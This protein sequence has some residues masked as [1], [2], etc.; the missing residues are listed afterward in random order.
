MDSKGH[1]LLTRPTGHLP[2]AKKCHRDSHSSEWP[3]AQADTSTQLPGE[4]VLQT[5]GM[6]GQPSPTACLLSAF[7]LPLHSPPRDC[8]AEAKGRRK[9]KR[10]RSGSSHGAFRTWV[11]ACV[12]THSR[13]ISWCVYTCGCTHISQ[14]GR[15]MA[16]CDCPAFL[17]PGAKRMHERP[18]ESWSGDI[19]AEKVTNTTGRYS[20][21]PPG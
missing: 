20:P 14:P 7:P 19:S 8:W 2:P 16:L 10:N 1:S 6:K 15:R 13:T 18:L 12:H 3:I 17:S 5:Q 4:K 21:G 9:L 11:R